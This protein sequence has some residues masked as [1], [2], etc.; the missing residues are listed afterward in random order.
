M[1][2]LNYINYWGIAESLQEPMLMSSIN[3]GDKEETILQK[4]DFVARFIE[5]FTV[6]RA[7]NYRKFGQTSIKYTMFNLIKRIRSSDKNN[8]SHILVEETNGI[9]Q[10]WE[11]ILKFGLHGQNRK[12]IK[13]LLSRISSYLDVLVGKDSSYVTYHH[14]KGKPFEIEHIWSD[15]FEEHRDEFEQEGEFQSW[16]NSIGG[17]ILLPNGTNQSYNSDKYESKIEHYLKENTYA[18]TLHEYYY[19]KNPNFLKSDVIQQ[20]QF[21]FHSEFKKADIEERKELVQR[22]CEQIWSIEYYKLKEKN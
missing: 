3:Y 15:K 9:E 21:K 19:K 4:I 16:R 22:I 1:P 14:P 6:R 11:G 2:H 20:L 17:L 10:S 13:H 5:S 12:F 8:L 7:I 18:Q